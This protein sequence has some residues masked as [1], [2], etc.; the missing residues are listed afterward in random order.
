MRNF[1]VTEFCIDVMGL[2]MIRKEDFG[3]SLR[4]LQFVGQEW[5]AVILSSCLESSD[6]PY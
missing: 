3:F 2:V 1:G 5:N 6:G 4:A